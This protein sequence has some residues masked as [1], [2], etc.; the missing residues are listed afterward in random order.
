MKINKLFLLL[1]MSA[2]I[3]TALGMYE[4]STNERDD[5]EAFNRWGET[6]DMKFLKKPGNNTTAFDEYVDQKNREKDEKSDLSGNNHRV[7]FMPNT[8]NDV[9]DNKSLNDSN[10]SNKGRS[11]INSNAKTVIFVGSI[12]LIGAAA[13][14]LAWN[15]R[16]YW[17][18]W[19]V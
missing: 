16:Y 13:A 4:K 12:A 3:G 9:S 19:V 6:I 11:S 2:S 18:K 1:L 7:I 5:A 15:A 17:E 8:Q 14:Y 10:D